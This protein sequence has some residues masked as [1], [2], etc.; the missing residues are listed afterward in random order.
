MLVG[1][2]YNSEEGVDWV[3]RDINTAGSLIQDLNLDMRETGN[4]PFT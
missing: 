2:A 3:A 1:G 4:S